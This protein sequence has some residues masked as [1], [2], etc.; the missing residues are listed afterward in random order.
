MSD[1]AASPDDVGPDDG[2]GRAVVRGS[3]R[4]VRTF[5]LLPDG[6]LGPV[7][8]RPAWR[9]GVNT[10]ACHPIDHP[11][12][13]PRPPGAGE[14]EAPAP[15]CYCGFWGY[16]NLQA[17]RDSGLDHQARVIAVVSCHGTVV[18]ATLGIR[19]QHARI[20]AVWLAARVKDAARAQV[21]RAYPET[22]IYRSLD[23]MLGE[24]ELSTL[25]TYDLPATPTRAAVL[26]P[27]AATAVWLAVVLVRL[28]SVPSLGPALPASAADL[29]ASVLVNAPL[30]VAMVATTAG[31]LWPR[32]WQWVAAALTAQTALLGL[33][34]MILTPRESQL[35][36]VTAAGAG[37][38]Q[39]AV[40]GVLTWRRMR[41]EVRRR[42]R[43]AAP[44]TGS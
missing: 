11:L 26:A 36:L 20:E 18:P 9:S 6:R 12:A 33:S 44:A 27:L 39:L 37:F 41:P 16:G 32:H 23:A 29:E 38:L 21:A 15:G 25:P 30:T 43:P 5:S 22:A 13:G 34:S 19:A 2:A 4:V 17:L 8:R 14:H 31:V 24:H 1:P 10:A 28:A 35:Q 42:R 3:V 7:T 40:C